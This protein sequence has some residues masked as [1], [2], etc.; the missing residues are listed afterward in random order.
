M[1]NG[2]GNGDG[3]F[4]TP[5]CGGCDSSCL[6]SCTNPCSGRTF[7]RSCCPTGFSCDNGHC[8]CPP[9]KTICGGVC[10]DT[11][12]D[13]NNCGW[14]GNQCAAGQTCQQGGCYP[15]PPV[16]GPCT[17]GFIE[18]CSLASPDQREC[19]LTP[20]CQTFNGP[21]TGAGGPDRCVTAGGTTQCCHSN[22]L[23]GW[24]PS[25]TVCGEM[26]PTGPLTHVT[27]GCDGPCW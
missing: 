21:C 20:C 26:T 13:P 16:C 6:K 17:N 5:V 24:F 12:T 7:S 3:G 25:I 22:W 18:C 23:Y 1:R 2:G 19:G 4:C 9:P 8:V 27:K 11:S 14:C 10:T 15:T